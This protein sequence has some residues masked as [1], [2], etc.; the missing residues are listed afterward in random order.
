[1]VQILADCARPVNVLRDVDDLLSK[2]LIL[3]ASARRS[4]VNHS[5]HCGLTPRLSH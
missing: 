4:A 1:M 3:I 5:P 2:P